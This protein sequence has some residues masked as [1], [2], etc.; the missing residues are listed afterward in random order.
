[1]VLTEAKF[2]KIEKAM[3]ELIEK[4]DGMTEI[5]MAMILKRSRISI[6]ERTVFNKFHERGIYFHRLFGRLDLSDEDKVARAE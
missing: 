4:S 2:K 6:G 5:T 1:M 3:D